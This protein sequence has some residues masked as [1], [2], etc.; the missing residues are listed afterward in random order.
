MAETVYYTMKIV[1]MF[2]P[3]I[4]DK[5]WK[6]TFMRWAWN[7]TPE[8]ELKSE[9]GLSERERGVWEGYVRKM[10]EGRV[11]YYEVGADG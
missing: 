5:L 1:I 8:G 4:T 10:S 6:D 11:G 7:L 2:N 9:A 3:P